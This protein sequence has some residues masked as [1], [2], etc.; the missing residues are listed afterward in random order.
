LSTQALA[1]VRMP[2][3][4]SDH[5]VLQREAPI[6]VWGWADPG[7]AVNVTFGNL[8]AKTVADASGHWK[9]LLD[10]SP[11]NATGQ[12]LIVAGKNTLEFKDVVVGDV[13]LCAGQ[14][15]MA[16][17]LCECDN[18]GEVLPK[19]GDPQLRIFRVTE[20]LSFTPHEDVPGLWNARAW[21][22]SAPDEV[23]QFSAV[24]YFFGRAL[25]SAQKVPI[26]LISACFG[27]TR[28]QLWLRDEAIARNINADPEFRDWIEKRKQFV[29]AQLKSSK[30]AVP[31]PEA[32]RANR[33]LTGI[34]YNG[35]IAPLTPF[36]IK[37]VIWYQGESNCDEAR[38]YRVLFPL[39]ISDW[40]AAWGRGDFPFLFVQ[41]PNIGNPASAAVQDKDPWPLLRDAQPK[42]LALP[43]TGMA[44][45]IDL[46]DVDVHPKSKVDVSHRLALLAR[47]RVYG[48]KIVDSGPFFKALKVE[49]ATAWL[50][51][52]NIGGGLVIGLPPEA[53]SRKV[54][55]KASELTGFAIA[56]EDKVWVRAKA[57]IEGDRIAV[58]SE[59]VP[60][61]VA[62]RYGWADNPPCNLYN[63][64][65]L[66]AAPFRTDDWER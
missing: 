62:V 6:A 31:T 37:G 28:A 16:L 23:G 32:A 39:L 66:P 61:P 47:N 45:T 33:F 43:N 8:T 49:G 35:M 55:P 19:S 7:E 12:T 29:D 27:G 40:R 56:G 24:A 41:L 14:S 36:T 59:R 22:L 25:R 11:A 5:M 4:F 53:P 57:R 34:I 26:G 9:V 52:E 38:P 15:N 46:G 44:V 60:K 1:E 21:R 50:S 65:K 48:E 63:T 54:A 13:W 64:E 30:D 20:R 18:A 42:A 10:K 17:Y 3:L 2:L 51:F 58:S